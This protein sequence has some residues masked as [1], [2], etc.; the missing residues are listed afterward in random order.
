[1]DFPAGH[2]LPIDC[3]QW[4]DVEISN[5][6]MPDAGRLVTLASNKLSTVIVKERPMITPIVSN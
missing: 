6:A 1:M 5:I 3:H 2:F 4:R